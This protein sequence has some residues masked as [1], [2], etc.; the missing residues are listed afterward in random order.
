MRF[1]IHL[2][3][4]G[5]QR[6]LPINYQY[7]LS[8]MIYRIIDRADSAFA[9]FLHTQ[10]Y[11]GNGRSFRLFT[12]SRLYLRGFRVVKDAGRI[13]HYGPD[14]YFEISFLID[15]AAQ[16]FIKGVFRDQNFDLADQ[17]SSVSYTVSSI[18]AMPVPVF[19][20][21]MH[22]RCLSPIFL[23]QK[24]LEGGEDYLGPNDEGYEDILLRNLLSK[25][26]AMATADEANPTLST[27][28]PE[29]KL[30]VLGKVYK[31]GVTIK[32]L[33]AQA[34]K[35]IGYIYEFKLTAPVQLHEIGY[36]AGFGHLNSQGFGCV[37]VKID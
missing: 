37:G 5:K 28:L 4:I 25:T 26:L 36:Y 6:F 33:S 8:A 21:A 32:Q 10:G 17:V 29:I 34:S 11:I 16:E 1:R 23:K 2:K 18:E 3:R 15:K 13:E 35:L 14:G 30:Q 31:K 20:P 9:D 7:E 22:Y 19:L 24:R 12:F 27:Q